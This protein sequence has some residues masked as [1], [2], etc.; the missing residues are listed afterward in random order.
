MVYIHII[1]PIYTDINSYYILSR[2]VG[3]MMYELLAQ[4]HPFVDS[5][6]RD[7]IKNILLLLI[8]YI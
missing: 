7:Y 6:V 2:A 3:I 5:K 4:K 8:K 1:V